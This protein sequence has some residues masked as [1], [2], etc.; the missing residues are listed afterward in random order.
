[1]TIT[2]PANVFPLGTTVDIVRNGTGS[3]TI[4]AGTNV[5]LRTTFT[6]AIRARYSAASLLYYAA[7]NEWLLAG[8][9]TAPTTT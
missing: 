6:T 7:G 8:D 5:L 3:V 1:M 2:I 4:A 9:T